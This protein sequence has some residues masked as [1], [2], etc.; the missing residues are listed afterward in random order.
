MCRFLAYKGQALLLEELAVLPSNSLITQSLQAKKSR[1]PVNADGFGLG[2][3]PLHNDPE[4]GKFVSIKPAW[5]DQN[6][7]QLTK[8]VYSQQFFA[9]VRDASPGMPVAEANCHPF[10]YKNFLW[11]HNGRLGQ[12]TKL[13]RPILNNLSDEAFHTIRG[14]TDSEYAFAMFLDAIQFNHQASTKEMAQAVLTTIRKI[15]KLRIAHGVTSNAFINFAVS[16]GRTIIVT[17]F[18]TNQNTKPAS[19]FYA[20]GTF[21]RKKEKDFRIKIPEK[22]CGTDVII[23][24]EP[25]TCHKNDWLKVKRNHMVIVNALGKVTTRPIAI[26]SNPS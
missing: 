11:M 2:W 3:Y 6:L 17:R 25:L 1:K 7:I 5:S 18:S 26:E 4:P 15:T 24:S 19:L 13:Q 10:Q 16:N 22:K 12:F 8:K 21:H 23:C 9:H 14:S 20:V